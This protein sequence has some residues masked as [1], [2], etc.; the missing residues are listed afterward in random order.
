MAHSDGQVRC[1]RVA[2]SRSR[3]DAKRGDRFLQADTVP[4]RPIPRSPFLD[5]F[6]IADRTGVIRR[7]GVPRGEDAIG[8]ERGRLRR[9]SLGNRHRSDGDGLQTR[10]GVTV[11]WDDP[12][13][14]EPHRSR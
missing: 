6:R 10:S 4:I 14:A 11:C 2:R 8:G 1:F 12:D 13:R 9:P 5:N 3:I 7:G